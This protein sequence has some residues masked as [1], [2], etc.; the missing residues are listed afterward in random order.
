MNKILSI[1][2]AAFLVCGLSGCASQ[3]VGDAPKSNLFVSK[4]KVVLRPRT[5]NDVTVL[6]T[7]FVTV[8]A[9]NFVTVQAAK[10][11]EAGVITPAVL[12]PIFL[13]SQT[14]QIASNTVQV[15]VPEVSYTELGKGAAIAPLQGV[16]NMIPVPGVGA[17]AGILGTLFGCVLSVIN[18]RRARKAQ[19]ELTYKQ[20]GHD[21]H[22]NSLQDII[23]T[24]RDAVGVLVSHVEDLR[25]EIKQM[26][27]GEAIDAKF[28]AGAVKLQS[29]MG[30]KDIV[31]DAVEQHT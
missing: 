5:T 10:T 28:M 18:A 11:N 7:N 20:Q 23:K 8:Y 17:G 29:M 31:A 9:T 2:T 25:G 6:T 16:A 13:P 27:N 19:D 22:V 1:L 21:A 24:G 4:D 26:P 3:P 30:V 14:A 15:I 12:Q